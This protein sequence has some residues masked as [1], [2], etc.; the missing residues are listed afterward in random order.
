MQ[1]IARG[2][3]EPADPRVEWAMPELDVPRDEL[4]AQ[5]NVYN[6]SI[7][8]TRY[9]DGKA[10]VRLVSA[11]E[12][13]YAMSG[14]IEFVTPVM[15]EDTI[16][17]KMGRNGQ[18]TAIWR[19]ASVE[20]IALQLRA[21]EPA[22]RLTLPMPPMVFVCTPGMP[23]RVYAAKA[24][25]ADR[26]DPLYRS[27]TFNTY[28]DGRVCP[29]THKFPMDIAEIPNS[30]FRSYFSSTGDSAGR[31]YKY[32]DNLRALWRELDGAEEYPM[33]DLVFQCTVAEAMDGN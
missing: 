20:K 1:K 25:P 26:N 33:D 5:I 2:N 18:S 9:R 19:E 22:T 27:P 23:P 31:S 30:F 28:A 13:A 6:E 8:L 15:D 7:T 10:A 32:P 14:R 29:G 24:R 21:H 12:L 16:W 3:E 11:D 17:W 4:R